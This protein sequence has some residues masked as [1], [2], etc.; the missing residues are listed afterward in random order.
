MIAG[1][2]T[3]R[4]NKLVAVTLVLC[5]LFSA[6]PPHGV[7]RKVVAFQT[8]TCTSRVCHCCA[9]CATLCVSFL[10]RHFDPEALQ[11][12]IAGHKGQFYID[13]KDDAVRQATVLLNGE[14]KW[15][16][17]PL[18]APPPP[19][20]AKAAAGKPEAPPDLRKAA[21]DN[22]VATAGGIGG[23]MALGLVSPSARPLT[24]TTNV[25]R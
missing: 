2:V 19:K 23:I 8:A 9:H 15:P 7:P 1:A 18:P 17:P 4:C 16:P 5:S 22:A 10:H 12:F 13:D 3:R 25:L 11:L 24:V 6:R 21:M 20:Q 14:L